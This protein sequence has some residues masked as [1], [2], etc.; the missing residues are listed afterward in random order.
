MTIKAAL[1]DERGIFLRIDE[2]ADASQLTERHLRSITS[3]DLPSG[4]YRW[5]KDDSNE[6]GGAFWSVEWLRRISETQRKADEDYA[7]Q[8]RGGR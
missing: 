1:L 6:Y 7:K 5:I 8:Q 2:L 3:C 4:Q